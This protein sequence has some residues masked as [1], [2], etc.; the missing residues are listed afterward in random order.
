LGKSVVGFFSFFL[1]IMMQVVGWV[2]WEGRSGNLHWIC[3]GPD[4][5]TVLVTWNMVTAFP[6]AAPRTL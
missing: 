5:C 4:D 3:L 1:F 2:R 6:M